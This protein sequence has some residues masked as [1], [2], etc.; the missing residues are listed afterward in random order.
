MQ[1]KA[2]KV[3]PLDEMMMFMPSR[4]LERMR[5][6]PMEPHHASQERHGLASRIPLIRG[7]G[8]CRSRSELEGC[9]KQMVS[10]FG[11]SLTVG[12]DGMGGLGLKVCDVMPEKRRERRAD[13]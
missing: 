5:T 6:Y 12:W 8:V 9:Q 3:F 4:H 2:K 10:L 1:R 13:G 7:F 11:R